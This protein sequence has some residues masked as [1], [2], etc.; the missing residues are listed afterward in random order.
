ME[1]AVLQAQNE[2]FTWNVEYQ[3]GNDTTKLEKV[4]LQDDLEDILEVL[5]VKL[6][7][8]KGEEV[9]IT[10]KIDEQTKK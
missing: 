7:N 5:D 3:F 9:K 1:K 6:M 10:P 2:E 4:T 8:E